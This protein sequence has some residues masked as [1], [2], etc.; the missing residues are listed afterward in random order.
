MSVA[1]EVTELVNELNVREP[2]LREIL[3]FEDHE[4]ALMLMEVLLEDYDSNLIAIEALSNCIAR[5]E[6]EAVSFSDFNHRID[7]EVPAV[8]LLKVLMYQHGLNTTDFNNEIGDNYMVS[9]MLNGGK[10]LKREHIYRLAERFGISS[11]LF[12]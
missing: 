4:Q 11:A 6:A 1:D 12:S 5:Y 8:A 7:F 3:S 9:Q 2:I 10:R